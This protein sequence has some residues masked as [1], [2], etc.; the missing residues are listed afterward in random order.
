MPAKLDVLTGNRLQQLSGHFNRFG[1]AFL[2]PDICCDRQ[3][4]VDWCLTPSHFSVPAAFPSKTDLRPGRVKDLPRVTTS[5]ADNLF[6]QVEA[7]LA[8]DRIDVEVA[9]KL[10]DRSVAPSP[11]PSERCFGFLLQS[12][13]RLWL[14][15]VMFLGGRS[16]AV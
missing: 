3:H 14:R 5:S 2:V 9:P 10:R 15:F 1:E 12:N 6:V 4:Q 7:A 16:T 8:H 13:F 11:R